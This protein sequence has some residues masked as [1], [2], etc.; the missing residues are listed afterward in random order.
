MLA[1]EFLPSPPAAVPSEEL[2]GGAL[3]FLNPEALKAMDE[4]GIDVSA[5]PRSRSK[6]I[7]R[8]V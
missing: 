4:R 1:M 3:H 2:P 5:V 8:V 6:Q 7:R